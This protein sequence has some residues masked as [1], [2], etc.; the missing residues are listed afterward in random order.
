MAFPLTPKKNVK[1]NQAVLA[2]AK[3]VC[4]E[5][6]EFAQNFDFSLKNL[7]SLRPLAG[8]NLDWTLWLK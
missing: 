5:Y 7:S 2:K 8:R 3:L 1:K 4:R 6:S